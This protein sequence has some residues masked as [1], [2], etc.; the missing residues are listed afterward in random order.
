[1]RRDDP[2]HEALPRVTQIAGLATFMVVHEAW[3]AGLASV[4]YL[5]E[6]AE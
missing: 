6:S 1:L 3:D 2:G 4:G 5:V